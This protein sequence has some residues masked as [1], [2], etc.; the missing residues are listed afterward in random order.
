MD[1]MDQAEREAL[2]R[3]RREEEQKIA[4]E[5]LRPVVSLV[6]SS[7]QAGSLADAI[8]VE[9]PTLSGQLCKWLAI[10]IM[11]RCC[12]PNWKPYDQP[13]LPGGEPDGDEW[14]PSE[15][16]GTRGVDPM[17]GNEIEPF[18]SH[19]LHDGRWGCHLV[20]GAMHMARQYLL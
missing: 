1:R 10:G 6:N 15:C 20:V 5:T 2:K 8:A 11:Q 19:P 12:G 14:R 16:I 13:W 4:E 18:E 17:T 3:W 7:W 9:H